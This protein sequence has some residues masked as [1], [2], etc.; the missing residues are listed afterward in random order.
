MPDSALRMRIYVYI[1]EAGAMYNNALFVHL[2]N[3]LYDP[4]WLPK[5]L[6]TIYTK[7]ALTVQN[8]ITPHFILHGKV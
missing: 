5:A 1:P 3:V 4:T 6:T 7:L 2:D 8:K